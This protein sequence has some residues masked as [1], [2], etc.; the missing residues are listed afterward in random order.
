VQ[1]PQ[2]THFSGLIFISFSQAREDYTM[3]YRIC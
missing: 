2:A 1:F 3:I